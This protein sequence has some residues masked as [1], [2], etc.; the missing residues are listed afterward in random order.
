MAK[1]IIELHGGE[2]SVESKLNEG[3]TFSVRIPLDNKDTIQNLYKNNDEN[4]IDYDT[5]NQLV[6]IEFSD[7]FNIS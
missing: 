7:I 1:A 6:Y 5:I 2:V 3:S 4:V